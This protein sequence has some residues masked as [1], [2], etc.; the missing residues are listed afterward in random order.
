MKEYYFLASLLPSLEIG[1]VPSLG[2][3]ELKT[4]LEAN[5]N[6]QDKI[7]TRRF[8]RL[9]DLENLRAYWAQ[10]PFDPR[11]NVG[12]EAM[13]QALATAQWPVGEEFAPFLQDYLDKYTSNEERLKYFP[14][15]MSTFFQRISEEE[16][17]F[18][19]DYFAFQ[20]EMRLVMVGFRAKRLGKNLDVELQYEDATDPVVAQI[21]AQKDAKVYEPPFEYK[22]LKPIFEEFIDS[23]IDLYK[24]VYE[25]QFNHI[26]ELWGGE[27]FT[28]DRILTYM[29]RLIL[30][31]RWLELD[32]QKGIAVL[33]EIER[34][35]G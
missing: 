32:M 4:L 25:Y 20:R 14:F 21:L 12:L 9:I 26:I 19:K 35:I 16:H 30:V 29:A 24:T 23:P 10:E 13:E 15:L 34:N 1:H 5:L 11:G 18:L 28:I 6:D 8:L 2:F 3:K 22:E 27:L 31:E 17:G 33:D 7:R